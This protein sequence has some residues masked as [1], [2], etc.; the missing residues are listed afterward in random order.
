MERQEQGRRS[1]WLDIVVYHSREAY[2]VV[3]G[4][5]KVS[6]LQNAHRIGFWNLENIAGSIWEALSYWYGWK[7]NFNS[8]QSQ[9]RLL[10]FA[11]NLQTFL[12]LNELNISWSSGNNQKHCN[13]ISK[14]IANINIYICLYTEKILEEYNQTV[15]VIFGGMREIINFKSRCYCVV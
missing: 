9:C 8:G 6:G 4:N 13:V 15:T 3:K 14:Y 10:V 7:S 1:N 12:L 11:S 2:D 5:F